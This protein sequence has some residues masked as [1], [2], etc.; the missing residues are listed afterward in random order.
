MHLVYQ[1]IIA[2]AATGRPLYP[3]TRI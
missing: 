3:R 1:T 2:S